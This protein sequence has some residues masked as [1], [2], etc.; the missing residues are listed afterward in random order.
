MADPT[1]LSS[2]C[3][4]SLVPTCTLGKLPIQLNQALSDLDARTQLTELQFKALI[5]LICQRRM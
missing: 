4:K 2:S 1:V 5:N 3:G